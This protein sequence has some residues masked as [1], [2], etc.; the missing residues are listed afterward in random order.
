MTSVSTLENFVSYMNNVAEKI[1]TTILN[2]M[3]RVVYYKPQ[4]RPTYSPDVFEYSE[5]L[6]KPLNVL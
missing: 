1:P 6:I 2:E 4:G 3:K 5:I